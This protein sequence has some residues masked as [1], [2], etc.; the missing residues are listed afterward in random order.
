[1]SPQGHALVRRPH[2]A[3]II[4]ILS[5]HGTCVEPCTT[6]IACRCPYFDTLEISASIVCRRRS[7]PTNLEDFPPNEKSHHLDLKLQ[8]PLF[9]DILDS[10]K[11][12]PVSTADP[13]RFERMYVRTLC[14]YISRPKG[15]FFSFCGI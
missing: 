15:I 12:I 13:R 5:L 8:G 1:M 14:I 4:V 3:V 2:I 9:F 7:F 6:F 11:E 10:A